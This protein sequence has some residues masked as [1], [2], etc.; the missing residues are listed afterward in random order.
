MLNDEDHGDCGSVTEHTIDCVAFA[1][2]D[3]FKS[4]NSRFDR[5]RFTHACLPGSNVRAKTAHLKAS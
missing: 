3:L 1:L 2:A 4:D 5:D